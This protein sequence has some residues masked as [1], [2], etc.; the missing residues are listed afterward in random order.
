MGGSR[1]KPDSRA[2]R[3]SVGKS[4]TGGVRQCGL[5]GKTGRLTRTECC[6]NWLCDDEENYVLFS[7]ARNSCRRNHRRY[8]LCGYHHTE[9]HSGSW[10]ECAACRSEIETEMYV[11]FGTNEYN[12]EK[13]E[14]PPSYRPTHCATCGAV[15]SLGEDGYSIRGNEYWCQRCSEDEVRRLLT[16]AGGSERNNALRRQVSRVPARAKKRKDGA[17]RPRR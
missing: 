17:T 16:G 7:Y 2:T 13:L 8:T 1:K 4:A 3:I 10:Q 9:E 11:Y 14:N 5:C 6:G 12:F 15:I